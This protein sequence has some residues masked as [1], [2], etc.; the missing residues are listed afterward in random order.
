MPDLVAGAP[1]QLVGLRGRRGR[2]VEGA[3]AQVRL[4]AG[5]VAGG[6][7]AAAGGVELAP[8]LAGLRHVW[9]G[10]WP[11]RLR[12]A[13]AERGSIA[14]RQPALVVGAPPL[15]PAA[16]PEWRAAIAA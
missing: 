11:Q 8:D 7:H 6:C 10:H 3:A 12:D 5:G 4:L 1:G 2:S 9:Q 15:P 13:T 14:A 16:T